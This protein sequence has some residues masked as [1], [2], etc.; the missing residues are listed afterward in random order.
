DYLTGQQP[1]NAVIHG[2]AKE[3]FFYLPAG[4]DAPNPAELLAKT[5]I[6]GLIDE[7]LRQFDR[8]VV[9]SAPIHAVSDTLLILNRIQTVCLV[10]RSRKTPKNSILRAVRILRQAEAPLVGV[11]LNMMP[12]NSDGYY[13]YDYAYYGKYTE[14]SE[15]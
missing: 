6:D 12:R 1:F 14:G 9:D 5:G 4:S 3:N 13:Y 10:V 11:I 2:A 7:A 8:V 15:E